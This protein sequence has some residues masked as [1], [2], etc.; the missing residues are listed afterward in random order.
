MGEGLEVQVV[1]TKYKNICG[2]LQLSG[3]AQVWLVRKG[4]HNAGG[5]NGSEVWYYLGEQGSGPGAA[6]GG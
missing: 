3:G 2:L 5:D 1:W 4:S 6:G